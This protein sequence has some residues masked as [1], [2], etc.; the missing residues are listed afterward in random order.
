MSFYNFTSFFKN[1]NKLKNNLPSISVSDVCSKCSHVI[2][3]HTHEFWIEEGYQEYRMEC[4]LCGLGE[5]SACVLPR[6]P[7]KVSNID[8]F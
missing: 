7:R 3:K 6:D 1:V 5:D 4:R 8:F 2:G